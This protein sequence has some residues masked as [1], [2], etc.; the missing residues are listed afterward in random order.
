MA[1]MR[2]LAAT[3]FGLCLGFV[4]AAAFARTRVC[5]RVDA[6][7]ADPSALRRLVTAEVDRHTTHQAVDSDCDSALTIEL[8]TLAPEM[9]SERYLTGRLDSEVPHREA[10]GASGMAAAVERLLTVILH[11]DPRRLRGPEQDDWIGRTRA[12]F[13]VRGTT[14]FGLELYQSS[15]IVG[16]RLQALPS[17]A[18]SARREIDRVHVGVRIGAASV[19]DEAEPELRLSQ[20]FLAQLELALFS[21]SES[22]TALFGAAVI[23]LEYQRYEGFVSVNQERRAESTAVMGLSGG[24][25]GGVE[26]LRT[27]D[28]RFQFFAQLLAPAFVAKDESG[29]LVDQWTPTGALGIAAWL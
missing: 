21:S 2:R 11:N 6:G 28:V 24:L 18:I 25:R 22:D 15:A 5:V 16:G 9:G 17:A 27:S 10:V 3:L 14:H 23:G 19:L 4:S 26:V 12:A 7:G 8:V 13:L 29:E 1:A 20:Q